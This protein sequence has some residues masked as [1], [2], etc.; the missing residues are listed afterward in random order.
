MR[1]NLL[2]LNSQAF[3]GVVVTTAVWGS[4]VCVPE[5][6]QAELCWERSEG[7]Y[8]LLHVSAVEMVPEL[9]AV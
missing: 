1:N 4:E 3:E 7:C 9:I 5:D 8:G 6:P 2:I